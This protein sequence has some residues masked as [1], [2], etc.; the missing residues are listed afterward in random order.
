MKGVSYSGE[1]IEVG[2][3]EEEET[4][5]SITRWKGRRGN[6]VSAI[7]FFVCILSVNFLPPFSLLPSYC[8]IE[9]GRWNWR[10]FWG[11][12]SSEFGLIW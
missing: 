10:D 4:G 7:V 5:G 11:G 12:N 2:L 6:I 8:F 3:F 1:L 9:D